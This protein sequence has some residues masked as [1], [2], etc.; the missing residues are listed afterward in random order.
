MSKTEKGKVAVVGD[1]ETLPLFKSAGYTVVEAYS[2][3]QALEAIA[4]L[5]SRGDIALVIVLKHI[6]D[7]E[8]KFKAS[9]TKYKVPVFVLPT[10]WALGEPVDVNKIIAKALGLG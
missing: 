10:R 1:R 5:E 3:S 4:R 2:Q 8:S 7:D 6:L 9:L